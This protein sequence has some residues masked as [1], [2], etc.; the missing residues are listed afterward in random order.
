MEKLSIGAAHLLNE[1]ID[2]RNDN[3]LPDMA[4]W[5]NRFKRMTV[6]ADD[7]TR[8]QF[9]ELIDKKMISVFWADNKPYEMKILND[10][11]AY[12]ADTKR[13]EAK[14]KTEKQNEFWRTLIVGIICAI[15]GVLA[16][17]LL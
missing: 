4:Y 5:D 14:E 16:G 10:G 7:V 6:D 15:I 9:K 11:W 3:N 8:S 12:D 1:I 2:N 17:K 13:E